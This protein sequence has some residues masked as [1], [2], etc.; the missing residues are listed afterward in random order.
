MYEIK[1]TIN[2]RCVLQPDPPQENIFWSERYSVEVGAICE[3]VH[4]SN[5]L[6]EVRDGLLAFYGRTE[7]LETPVGLELFSSRIT[8]EHLR[9]QI[10]VVRW[11]VHV[12][13]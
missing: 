2:E 9:Q 1:P 7:R 12:S 4:S 3:D 11:C 5:E 8:V 6:V 10:H 13:E